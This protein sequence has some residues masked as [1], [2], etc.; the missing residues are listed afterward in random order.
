MTP[1]NEVKEDEM[2]RRL[3]LAIGGVLFALV[4]TAPVNGFGNA[5]HTTVLSFN[6]PFALPGMSLPAGTYVF[7][8]INTEA[9]LDVVRVMSRDRMKTYAVRLT[10]AVDRPRNLASNRQIVFGE[11][12]AGVAPRVVAWYPLDSDRGHAFIY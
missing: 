7:E 9:S 2:N 3:F 12:K 10:T 6:T 1:G 8:R 5:H 11:A 4:S